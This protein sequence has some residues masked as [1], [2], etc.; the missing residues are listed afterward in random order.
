MNSVSEVLASGGWVTFPML[1]LLIVLFYFL[2]LRY[3]VL[4]FVHEGEKALPIS[5]WIQGQIRQLQDLKDPVLQVE[6]MRAN[7]K[8]QIRIGRNVIKSLVVVAPL[9]GLLGTVVGMIET[10]DSLGS[11]QMYS[12]GGGIAQGI[13]QA[14]VT[15]EMGLIIS[16]PGL[17]VARWLDQKEK[18]VWDLFQRMIARQMQ[19]VHS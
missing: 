12:Q 19:G 17:L 4:S 2:G 11:M 7:F 5:N 15:T 14:M 1:F 10:F 3:S 6:L 9:L 16:I 8:Q 13:S 18:S